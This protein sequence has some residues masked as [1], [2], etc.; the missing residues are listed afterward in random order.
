MLSVS[1]GGECEDN[2][3]Q[4]WQHMT[5]LPM[6]GITDPVVTYHF[7]AIALPILALGAAG[8]ILLPGLSRRVFIPLLLLAHFATGVWLLHESRRPFLDVYEETQD[9]CQALSHAQNPYA[10]TFPDIYAPMPAWDRMWLAAGTVANGR[11][12]YGYQYMPLS[13]ELEWLGHA[14]AGD[15]RLANLL[16]VTLAGAFLAYAVKGPLG[17]AAASLLLLTPRG[18][19]IIEQ[20]WA[21]PTAL[22]CLAAVVFLTARKSAATPWAFGLLLISKQYVILTAL[23]GPLLLPK[24]WRKKTAAPFCLRS[25]AAGA[26]VT[27]PLV[28]LNFPAFWHSA[29]FELMKNPFRGDALSFAAI[30]SQAGHAPPPQ[31]FAFAAAI[32]AGFI[33]LFRAPRTPAGFAAAIALILICFFTLAKQAFGNYY[34]LAI[35]ALCSCVAASDWRDKP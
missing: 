29:V 32:I 3:W 28:L 30:W 21:E 19:Y 7:C 16:A 6:A 26:L 8:S 9:S 13:L 33:T 22:L 1:A 31:W 18:Y 24:P 10:M 23:A 25:I 11:T 35:G 5:E 14:I 20:G 17:P 27:L 4:L 15:F 34:F 2:A 12:Q